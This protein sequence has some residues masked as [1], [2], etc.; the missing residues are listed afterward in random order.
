MQSTMMRLTCVA[1]L[2][3]ALAVGQ[4]PRGQGYVFQGLGSTS[5]DH[6]I[7]LGQ[8]GAGGEGVFWKG[9]GVGGDLGAVY[10]YR[11]LESVVGIANVS[12][13]YHFTA[14]RSDTKWDPFV[15]GGYTLLFRGGTANGFH[16][17]GGFGYWFHRHIGARVEFRDQRTRRGDFSFPMVRFGISFR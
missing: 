3:A 14:G 15:V 12:G 6:G 9:L 10:P 13:V 4:V 2:F 16:W 8:T 17:G 1:S 11:S 7:A 5:Y